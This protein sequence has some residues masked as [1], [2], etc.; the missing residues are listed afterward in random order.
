MC[1]TK[2][3]ARNSEHHQVGFWG[4]FPQSLI[5]DREVVHIKITHFT[6]KKY[7][8]SHEQSTIIDYI[9]D[10]FKIFSMVSYSRQGS[11]RNN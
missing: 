7:R 11:H 6:R 8:H 5:K 2:W 3:C 10:G 1:Y 9:Q 4:F